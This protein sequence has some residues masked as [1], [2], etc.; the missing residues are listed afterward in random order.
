LYDHKIQLEADNNLGFHP[1]YKQTAAELLAT[2]Q[3]LIENLGKGFINHSQA[4]FASLILFVK[5]A[6]SSL[7]FCIDYQ[8]LNAITRKDQ[9]PLPLI[10]E[11]L[12]RLSK[13]KI[14]TKLDI[15]QVFHQIQM[16]PALE[17]LTTF[18]TCYG[19]YKCKVL[20]FGLTN[21]LAIY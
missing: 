5:K 10:D 2:K 4:L 8:K 6:N 17:D 18:W 3:Y 13:A 9:Y 14:F 1:L 21:G 19:T 20:P 11:T 7:R 15:R 12:A 16:D